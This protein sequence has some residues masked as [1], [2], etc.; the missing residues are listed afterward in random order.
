V[1]FNYRPRGDQDGSLDDARA[2][3]ERAA[4]L[5]GWAKDIPALNL[6]IADPG[7]KPVVKRQTANTLAPAMVA[8]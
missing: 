1:I 5:I 7:V 8:A 2:L 6:A 4:P 3:Q